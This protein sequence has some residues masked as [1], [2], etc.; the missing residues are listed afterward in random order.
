MIFK[1][2]V[3]GKFKQF[4]QSA[5]VLSKCSSA[6]STRCNGSHIIAVLYTGESCII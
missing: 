3:K 1:P 5:V 2:K 4:F 6:F